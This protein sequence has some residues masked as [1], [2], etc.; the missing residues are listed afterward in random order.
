MARVSAFIGFSALFMFSSFAQRAQSP[1][2]FDTAEIRASAPNTMPQMRA[3]FG[4]GRYE[5]RNATLVDLVRTAWNVEADEVVGGPVWADEDRFDVL[6]TAAPGSTLDALRT[7]LQE[8][9]KDRFRLS[10]HNGN[11]DKLA[12]AITAG[13]K[14]ELQQA[15]GSEPSGCAI[16]PGSAQGIPINAPHPPVTLVCR[17][18]TMAAFSKTL[19]LIPEASGYVFTY[20]VLDRT[21]L[22]GAWNFHLRWSPENLYVFYPPAGEPI[23][24]FDAFDKQLGLKL[25]LVKI[26]APVLVID[27]ASRPAANETPLVLPQFEV[28]DIKPI[29]PDDPMAQ[30]CGSVRID[31]GGRVSIHMAL[32]MLIWESWGAPFAF[33]R[34]FGGSKGMDSPCWEVL[35]KAPVEEHPLG[36]ASPAGWNGALWN[37]LDLDT[38]RMMLRSFLIDRFKLASHMED[39]MIDGYALTA[40]KP[41]L[42]PANPANHPGCK[43]GPGDDGKDPRL[44]N[45][46]ASRL[47]TCR[48]MTVAQFAAELNKKFPGSPPYVDATG[49]TG[50]YDMTINFSPVG[51]AAAAPVPGADPTAAEP[52]GAISLADALNG[53]LGLKA[54]S[55]KVTAPVLVVD[56]V[57][58]APTAN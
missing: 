3:S 22:G 19:P 5:L 51:V 24:I 38:M 12:F 21:G 2:G 29:S 47:I 8:L 54:Q 10:I 55:R 27:R 20:G 41:K 4:G 13:K 49:L 26:P 23:T 7:M 52:N 1:P 45:P 43:E 32:R 50:R 36:V 28:A 18:I 25:E 6:A 31:P 44:T 15:D 33:E 46:I 58:D 48:N 17:N 57:E 34:F 30:T 16:D 39:R 14:P 40:A 56:H 37:G 53:Q 35:A 9:L 11:R 42:K